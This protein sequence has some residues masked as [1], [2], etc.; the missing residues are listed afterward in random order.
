MALMCCGLITMSTFFVW[1]CQPPILGGLTRQID[2]SVKAA[3]ILDSI[4]DSPVSLKVHANTGMPALDD[5]FRD[6]L[7]AQFIETYTQREKL[8]PMYYD[9]SLSKTIRNIPIKPDTEHTKK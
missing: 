7:T 3:I 9:Q 1:T 5:L 2:W 4:R 6:Y 8:N